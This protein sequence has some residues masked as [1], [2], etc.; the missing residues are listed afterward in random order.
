M[1]YADPRVSERLGGGDALLRVHGEHRVDQVLRLRRHRV[2][3][4]RRVLHTN[5]TRTCTLFVRDGD[6]A[7]AREN[8]EYK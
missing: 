3:L 8:R 5:D 4:G 6:A 2:P 7:T 1:A